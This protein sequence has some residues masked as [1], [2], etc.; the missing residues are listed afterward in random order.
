MPVMS[1]T[2]ASAQTPGTATKKRRAQLEAQQLCSPHAALHTSFDEP[3]CAHTSFRAVR[4][5]LHRTESRA[6]KNEGG[7]TGSVCSLPAASPSPSVTSR[8]VTHGP[9]QRAGHGPPATMGAP[10]SICYGF[11]SKRR[12]AE[13]LPSLPRIGS[14]RAERTCSPFLR[15]PGAYVEGTPHECPSDTHTCAR[16]LSRKNIRQE[17]EE[18]LALY[19]EA[20]AA[21]YVVDPSD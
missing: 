8:L 3:S 15:A 18:V 9:S 14:R 12:S 16:C 13:S 10:A 19:R 4:L 6:E 20:K 2:N 7:M 11:F 1:A 21:G 17:H 5:R